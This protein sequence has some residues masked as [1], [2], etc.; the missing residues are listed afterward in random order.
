MSTIL[1]IDLTAIPGGTTP[2]AYVR[3][4][5]QNCSNPR[6]VGSGQIVP[7]T[8]NLFPNNGRIVVTLF[9]NSQISCGT[10]NVQSDC[11]CQS[12]NNLVSYYSFNFIYQG[13]VTSVG[14]YRLRA[15]TFNLWDLA[16]CVGQDCICDD[17]TQDIPVRSQVPFGVVDGVN[18]VFKLLTVPN[19]LWLQQNGVFQTAGIDYT[20]SG[21]TINY[22][23]PPTGELYAIYTCGSCSA[24]ITSEVPSGTVDGVNTVFTTTGYPSPHAIWLYVNGIYQTINSKFTLNGN[25]ITFATPPPLGAILYIDYATATETDT[26]YSSIS[27]QVPVGAIDGTNTVF[28]I[29]GPHRFVMLQQNQ[30]FLQPGVGYMQTGNTLNLVQAPLPGDLLLAT[31]FN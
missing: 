21:N 16:P 25:V 18:T 29:S 17:G 9:D 14:S 27:T 30:G 3:V 20:L 8:I 10:V 15:G 26:S 23:Y 24:N 2:G 13:E 7:K 28:T 22:L 31:L 1:T 19:V 11:G 4:D 5:L 6:V 12:G